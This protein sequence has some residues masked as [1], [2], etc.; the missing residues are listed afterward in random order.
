M[1]ADGGDVLLQVGPVVNLG[2]AV[3]HNQRGSCGA[4]LCR[5]TQGERRQQCD[6]GL[7][8]ATASA[9]LS[10]GGGSGDDCRGGG[11]RRTAL[12]HIERK[13]VSYRSG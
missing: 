13:F 12:S 8:L 9:T 7:A 11:D 2:L 1:T 6:A 3:R 4:N 5:E 10:G